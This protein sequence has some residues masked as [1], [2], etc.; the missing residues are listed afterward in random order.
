[1]AL[2]TRLEA[3]GDALSSM[4]REIPAP[5]SDLRFCLGGWRHR[6]R[7]TGTGQINVCIRY[8]FSFRLDNL[9]LFSITVD[10]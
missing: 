10:T 3:M 6:A 2:R 5:I 4:F 1:M 8:R 7:K 9:D